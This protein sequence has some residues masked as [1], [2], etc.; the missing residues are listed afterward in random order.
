MNGFTIFR[1]RLSVIRSAT[2]SRKRR[3]GAISLLDQC[4]RNGR[5]YT[6][7]Y[8]AEAK[9]PLSGEDAVWADE[10]LRQARRR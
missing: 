8:K 1:L 6:I 3:G 2:L 5:Y 7:D 10:I 4:Y 9:P